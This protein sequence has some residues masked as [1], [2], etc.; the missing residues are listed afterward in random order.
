MVLEN[1]DC[2]LSIVE[3]VE[4]IMVVEFSH[5]CSLAWYWYP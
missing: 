1:I 5:E 2:K 4:V 3:L